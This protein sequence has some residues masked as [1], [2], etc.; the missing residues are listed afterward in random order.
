MEELVTLTEQL[1]K[2]YRTELQRRVQEV[3]ADFQQSAESSASHSAGMSD[4]LRYEQSE[5]GND[6]S[7]FELQDEHIE[8]ENESASLIQRHSGDRSLRTRK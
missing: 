2:K 1:Q 5:E 7:S 6:G 8:E 4:H 3:I